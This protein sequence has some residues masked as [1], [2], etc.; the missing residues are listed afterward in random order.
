MSN[1]C[2]QQGVPAAEHF[3]GDCWFSLLDATLRATTKNLQNLQTPDSLNTR[4]PSMA[5]RTPGTSLRH[6]GLTVFSP[7]AAV[8]LPSNTSQ[9]THRW[10]D[11]N[12][13]LRLLS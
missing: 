2:L 4:S 13:A 1:C 3:N 8:S 9:R 7:V 6:D 5:V 11:N 12:P 10:R